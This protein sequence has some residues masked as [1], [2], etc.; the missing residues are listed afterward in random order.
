[1]PRKFNT[2]KVFVNYAVGFKLLVA[3]IAASIRRHR[4]R[5]ETVACESKSRITRTTLTRNGAHIR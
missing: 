4:H 5:N 2:G 1:M 3:D